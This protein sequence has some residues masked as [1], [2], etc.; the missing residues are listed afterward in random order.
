MHTT[1]DYLVKAGLMILLQSCNWNRTYCKDWKYM[2]NFF[3]SP[4]SPLGGRPGNG[5]RSCFF[6]FMV[7]SILKSF[8]LLI[9]TR[10]TVAPSWGWKRGNTGTHLHF[11]IPED[12]HVHTSAKAWNPA[13]VS[14][15]ELGY[16][17][18]GAFFNHWINCIHFEHTVKEGL[19][20]SNW[21]IVKVA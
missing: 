15:V 7:L 2:D 10:E 21:T 5:Q 4:V 6:H 19:L 17:I 1:L 16:E 14:A 8:I 13:N 9:I 12:H 3:S 20:E 18:D 11:I